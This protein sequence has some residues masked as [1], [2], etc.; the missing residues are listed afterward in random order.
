MAKLGKIDGYEALFAKA[1]PKSKPAITYDNVGK[2]IGLRT[3]FVTP[4]RFDKLLAGEE[5]ALKEPEIRGLKDLCRSVVW[6]VTRAIYSAAMPTKN[7]VCRSRGQTKKI[8]G[9]LI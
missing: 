2:A 4:G 9:G 3:V 5:K 8:R 6:P 1:F 7:W